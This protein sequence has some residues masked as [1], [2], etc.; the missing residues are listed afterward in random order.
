[1]YVGYLHMC[2][3]VYSFCLTF[4]FNM[5]ESAYHFVCLRNKHKYRLATPL[6]LSM[7]KAKNDEG[8]NDPS[9]QRHRKT[10]SR[11][12]TQNETKKQNTHLKRNI[13]KPA[14]IEKTGNDNLNNDKNDKRT[15]Q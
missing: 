8:R 14:G 4:F 3:H 11:K 9:M 5:A 10:Q 7:P 1:M 13:Q 12:N 6:L 2:L 15:L